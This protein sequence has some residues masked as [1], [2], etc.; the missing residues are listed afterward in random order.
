MTHTIEKVWEHEGSTCVVLMNNSTG[1][2]CGYVGVSKDHPFFGLDYSAKCPDS[3]KTIWDRIKE[4]PIGKMGV[5][6]LFTLDPENPRVGNI[7]DVH[8]GITY[9]GGNDNYPITKENTWWFGYDCG[10]NGDARDLS[11]LSDAQREIEFRFPTGGVV[12]TLE[13]CIS[14][15]ESLSK[16]LTEMKG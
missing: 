7:F 2:R 13:Y 15:C 6:D 10:H 14:E 8:G 16:Q 3:F 5:I 4:G 12:R 9:S 1:H 11:V